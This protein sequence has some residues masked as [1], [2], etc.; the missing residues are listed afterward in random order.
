[1]SATE[2]RTLLR[3]CAEALYR[4][5]EMCQQAGL[6][7]KGPAKREPGRVRAKE[8]ARASARKGGKHAR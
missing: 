3:A 8:R 2:I 5:L 4:H 6:V 1:M 7:K